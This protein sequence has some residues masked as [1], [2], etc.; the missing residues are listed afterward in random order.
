MS[1][2]RSHWRGLNHLVNI[3]K[4]IHDVKATICS[5]CNIQC[6]STIVVD[7]PVYVGDRQIQHGVHKA[8]NVTEARTSKCHQHVAD[9]GLDQQ[10]PDLAGEKVSMLVM[11]VLFISFKVLFVMFHQ[12]Y[13]FKGVLYSTYFFLFPGHL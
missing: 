4:N 3:N 6:V 1:T 11:L 8:G 9:E 5:P 7:L 10:V 12:K 2:I 13:L